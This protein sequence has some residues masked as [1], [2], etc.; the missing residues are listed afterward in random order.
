MSSITTNHRYAPKLPSHIILCIIAVLFP[1][2]G[3]VVGAYGLTQRDPA[4][5]NTGRALLIC[6][7]AGIVAMVLLAALLLVAGTALTWW[8]TNFLFSTITSDIENSFTVTIDDWHECRQLPSKSGNYKAS[9][10]SK[11]IVAH[12]TVTNKDEEKHSIDAGD[13][14]LTTDDQDTYSYYEEEVTGL[15]PV[16]ATLQP[17]ESASG[18]VEFEVDENAKPISIKYT[19]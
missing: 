2:I 5:Q 9:P 10:G 8:F 1:I 14:H 13:L 18:Y 7:V 4:W 16:H 17:G 3:I 15:Q 19:F 6:A 11:F 12:V